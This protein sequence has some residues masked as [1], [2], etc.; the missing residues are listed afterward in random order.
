MKSIF[1]RYEQKY[2]ISNKQKDELISVLR[3][4][5]IFDQYSVDGTAY[6]VNNVY[7]DTSD[8][9]IIRHSISK[10]IYKEKLRL[11]YYQYPLSNETIVYLEIKKKYSKRVN[12]RRLALTFEDARSYLDHGIAPTLTT[13]I[14]QQVFKEIDYF[15]KSNA[16]K[17]NT[18][19]GYHRI[20]MVSPVSDLRVTFDNLI[21]F[22]QARLDYE[23]IPNP[24]L[25][26]DNHYLVE[27]KSET[28][29]PLWLVSELSKL[30]AYSISFSKYGNAYRQYLL[31]GH[32]ND[33]FVYLA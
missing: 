9:Q 3:K 32:H 21:V 13:Y 24:L 4:Y 15:M 19:I 18:Y 25:I 27:L 23:V 26:D 11:R 7:Y 6:H 22:D 33:Y 8:N 29:L 12:K 28:N 10:P 16:V 2:L 5:M 17:P 1:N 20:A 31:G 30:E 14:D